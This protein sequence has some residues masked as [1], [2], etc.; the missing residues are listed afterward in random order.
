VTTEGAATST[1]ASTKS[2]ETA[3]AAGRGGLAIAAA[4]VS[5]ML[6]GTAQ[7]IA[8]AHLLGD[9]VWGQVARVFVA[10]NPVNNVVV[11][12]SIQGVSHAVASA[13]E[14]G[15]RDAQRQALAV[16]VPVALGIAAVFAA[17]AGRIAAALGAE[18]VAPHLRL[19]A[20]VVLFYGLYAPLVGSLNG[21]RRFLDQAKLD[22][23]YGAMRTAALLAGAIAAGIWGALVGFAL[24]AMIIVPVAVVRARIR[25]GG[26][27]GEG[28]RF[29]RRAYLRY[30]APT[31]ASQ[32]ALNLL[33]QIDAALLSRFLGEAAGK[34]RAVEADKLF[35]VYANVQLFS[36]LPYQLLIS[37]SFVLFPMLARAK[38]DGDQDAVRRYTMSGVRLAFVLT[39][40]FCGVIAS[41]GPHLLR[42]V[43]SEF[44][45]Q[46]G[47]D[48]LRVLSLAMGSFTILGITSAALTS[49]D[50]AVHS[51][52]L[53]ATA[54]LLIAVGCWLTVPGAE[55]GAP[56]LQKS[57][58]AAFGGLTLTVI[59]GAIALRRAAGGFVPLG[60]L[61]R[62]LGALG[63]CIFVG[64]RLPWLGKVAVLAEAAAIG[65]LYIGILVITREVGRDDLARIKQVIGRRA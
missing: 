32:I 49:L 60:T 33:M 65:L 52:V 63:V 30:L 29:D 62:V 3:K 31:F 18:H 13:P 53:T 4:K 35:G 61:V 27:A 36:F 28:P 50:R 7:K 9:A 26:A 39:G 16:H 51:M 43:F 12:T 54:V 19:V 2:D 46:T 24:A 55:F 58:A 48:A 38:A 15:A 41:L 56:M 21:Q 10:L 25:N 1:S 34:A 37:V 42:F 11:G 47:G 8:L 64:T 45:S 20:L 40:L 59:F 23:F 14:G 5:F 57:A 17:S 44:V 22:I 6:F